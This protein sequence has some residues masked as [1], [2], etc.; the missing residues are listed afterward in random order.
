MSEVFDQRAQVMRG[1]VRAVDDTGVTQRVDAEVG[2]NQVRPGVHVHQPFGF[3]SVPPAEGG[4]VVVVIANGGDP[5]DLVALPA[6]VPAA[7]LGGLQPGSVAIYT[8]DG[9]RV[10]I[11]PDGTIDVHS[12]QAVNVQ[13]PR[14]TITGTVTIAGDVQLQGSLHVTGDVT[15]DG[16]ITAQGHITGH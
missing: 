2:D 6:E 5:S 11:H 12:S 3:A 8:V 1:I 10:L 13:A 15:T 4:G 9:S 16:N 14:V 7:R